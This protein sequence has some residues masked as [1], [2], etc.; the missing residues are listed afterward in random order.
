MCQFLSILFWVIIA[1]A[2]FA[3]YAAVS[4]HMQ[5]DI[6][7]SERLPRIIYDR[8]CWLVAF[9][10]LSLAAYIASSCKRRL[11]RGRPKGQRE[12]ES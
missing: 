10:I 4:F 8:N 3:L 5:Q 2:A 1:A 12:K 6:S 11:R 9:A 7:G